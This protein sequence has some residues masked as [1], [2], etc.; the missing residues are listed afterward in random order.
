VC[1]QA[2]SFSPGF[3]R[4]NQGSERNSNRFNGFGFGVPKRLKP[5]KKIRLIAVTRLKPGENEKD[6]T[7]LDAPNRLSRK[8][9]TSF[10]S[11]RQ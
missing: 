2:I 7:S 6:A 8:A 3:N 1:W 4:V 5:L 11:L 10:I 9:S